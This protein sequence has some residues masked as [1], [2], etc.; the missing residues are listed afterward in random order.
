VWL[1]EY[2]LSIPILWVLAVG[3]AVL[4]FLYSLTR[5][6]SFVNALKSNTLILAATLLTYYVIPSEVLPLLAN[7]SVY[8]FV[9]YSL[10]MDEAL[11]PNINQE[12]PEK[13]HTPTNPTEASPESASLTQ[14]HTADQDKK[15]VEQVH[16][17]IHD[18]AKP[19]HLRSLP[20]YSYCIVF[21]IF[22][23]VDNYARTKPTCW[24]FL[25]ACA[26]ALCL[27]GLLVSEIQYNLS[28]KD[29]TL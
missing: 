29:T 17:P 16:V 28:T 4:L 22:L 25:A 8:F 9:L 18:P 2:W 21:L 12:K 13:S 5:W 1:L 24:P 19:P 20:S 3:Q 27:N 15:E 26:L 23:W 10:Y 6:N 14:S 7:T 11:T